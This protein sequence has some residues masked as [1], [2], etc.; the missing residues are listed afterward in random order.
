[1]IAAALLTIFALQTAGAPAVT[2]T[3]RDSSG[4]P[5]AAASVVVRTA[6]GIEERTTSSAEG[7]FTIPAA[8]A[9]DLTLIVRADGFAEHRTTTP[10]GQNRLNIEVVLSPATLTETVTVTAARTEQLTRNVAASVNVL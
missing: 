7:R 8:G 6:S 5:L 9:A 3:V 10:A 1:M 2:G 4:M